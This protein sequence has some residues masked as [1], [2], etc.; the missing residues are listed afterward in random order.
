MI[1]SPNS[2][3]G[4][5]CGNF[6]KWITNEKPRG[7]V[8]SQEPVLS[9]PISEKDLK[10]EQEMNSTASLEFPVKK[11]FEYKF[12]KPAVIPPKNPIHLENSV[13]KIIES[14]Q[15]WLLFWTR[16]CHDSRTLVVIMIETF[17]GITD[18]HLVLETQ[19]PWPTTSKMFIDSTIRTW[20]TIF[21]P[22]IPWFWS[23]AQNHDSAHQA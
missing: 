8:I 13:E 4:G 17:A 10:P 9:N 1:V 3:L 18:Q 22:G 21:E 14:I 5:W 15:R 6:S 16:W 19:S 20:L 12:S 23:A 2:K 11:I 7:L